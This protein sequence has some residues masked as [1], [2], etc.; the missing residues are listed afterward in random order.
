[1]AGEGAVALTAD[2]ASYPRVDLHVLLERT[3]CL[4]TLPAQQTEDSH[5]CA[6][7]RQEWGD[8]RQLEHRA[9]LY[10]SRL[11]QESAPGLVPPSSR[12]QG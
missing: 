10:P 7:G 4:E 12:A 9:T 6:C 11:E 2:V 5:V 8:L 1:M 3:L